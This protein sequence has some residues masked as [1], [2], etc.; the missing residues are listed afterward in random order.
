M[1][2][3]SFILALV[4]VFSFVLVSCGGDYKAFD[5]DPNYVS[6]RADSP[7]RIISGID[8]SKKQVAKQVKSVV[9]FSPSAAL[10]LEEL[11][12]GGLIKGVD[13]KTAKAVANKQT[14]TIEKIAN[15]KPDVVFITED[16]DTS[17]LD[18]AGIVYFYVPEVLTVNDIKTLIKI[19]EKMINY[20]D[21]SLAGN[22]DTEYT[23]AK[24]N[25]AGGSGYKTF[26]DLGSLETTG[27]GTFVNEIL[28]MCGCKNVFEDK[29]GYFKAAKADIV[30][31]DPEVIFTTGN[32]A[33]I[34]GDKAF[35]DVKAVKD[36]KVFRIKGE[37]LE[38]GSST[39]A[40]AISSIST[41]LMSSKTK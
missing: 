26:I 32:P 37:T 24:Q 41:S 25:A 13:A 19:E 15:L 40:D 20:S 6:V 27:V 34:M 35:A 4:I 38:Y 18:N 23:L 11:G 2:K 21:T 28:A 9:C 29:E 33:T 5:I 3:V 10:V 39:I 16:Y 7:F 12:A 22:I 1:K 31:A 36:K 8:G 30:E 14:I 17:A